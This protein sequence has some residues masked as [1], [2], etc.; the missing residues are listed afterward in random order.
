MKADGS[1]LVIDELDNSPFKGDLYMAIGLL[2]VLKMVPWGDV[3]SNAPKI[4]D[5]AMKLWR[6]VAKKRQPS[7]FLASGVEPALATEVQSLAI[8]QAQQVA[9]EAKVS[10]LHNQMLESSELIKALADQNT[11][12]IKRFEVIRARVL[13]LAGAVVILGVVTAIN[14]AV[15]LAR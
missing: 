10:D 6:T 1:F 14:L 5:E 12:L 7:E 8:L 3:I 4:S 9:A 13:L 15:T 2:S 11:Q